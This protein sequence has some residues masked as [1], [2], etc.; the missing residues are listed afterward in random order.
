LYIGW[1]REALALGWQSVL[2]M[3]VVMVTWRL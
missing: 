2:Q 1:Q 3:G